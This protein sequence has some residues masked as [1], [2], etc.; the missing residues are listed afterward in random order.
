MRS[1]GGEF[2]CPKLRRWRM[3]WGCRWLSWSNKNQGRIENRGQHRS[4]KDRLSKLDDCPGEN[5]NSSAICL[6]L[7]S[8]PLRPAE[9]VSNPFDFP[10]VGPC[11]A[12]GA[13]SDRRRAKA[14]GGGWPGTRAE[15][16]IRSGH[17]HLAGTRPPPN[18]ACPGR[19]APS[20]RS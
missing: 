18:H 16:S 3:R 7:F 2:R 19:L 14:R 1:V 5:R 13:S 6:K 17:R 15:T 8:K 12:A 10:W 4:Y 20:T 11:G 9:V